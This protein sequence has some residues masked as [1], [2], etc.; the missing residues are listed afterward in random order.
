MP[1]GGA[2]TAETG[3]RVKL[4]P[5]L[6]LKRRRK[7]QTKMGKTSGEKRKIKVRK[8]SW[9]FLKWG[10]KSMSMLTVFTISTQR[11][12]SSYSTQKRLYTLA[13]DKKIINHPGS[14]F[15][16]KIATGT[17]NKGKTKASY[18]SWI[19]QCEKIRKWETK[20]TENTHESMGAAWASLIYWARD[21]FI[22]KVYDAAAKLI[23]RIILTFLASEVIDIYRELKYV[24][25]TE[26]GSSCPTP[27]SENSDKTDAPPP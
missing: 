21:R 10:L 23:T 13:H 3:D 9:K 2:E 1:P 7:P 26:E 12:Q 19:R 25:E 17:R 8:T 24:F 11:T 20:T 5:K 15:P 22:F 16:I 4:E 18:K 27:P 14:A 6:K